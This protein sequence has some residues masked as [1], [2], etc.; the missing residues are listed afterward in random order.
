MPAFSPDRAA[1]FTQ[2][3]AV[4]LSYNEFPDFYALLGIERDAAPAVLELAII[5]RGADVLAA[6][7]GRGAG[8][9]LIRLLRRYLPDFRPILLDAENRRRYNDQLRRHQS[10]DLNALPYS[11]WRARLPAPPPPQ[12]PARGLRARLRRAIWESDYL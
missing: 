12:A 7:L 10:G 6:S 1:I 4:P 5:E 9:E 2:T 11:D 3:A 8:S